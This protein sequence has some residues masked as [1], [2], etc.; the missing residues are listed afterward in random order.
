VQVHISESLR[1]QGLTDA[2][3]R[4]ALEPHLQK[5][6]F[7]RGLQASVELLTAFEGKQGKK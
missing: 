6:D 2:Q 1:K 4:Q 7:D 3:L 5:K